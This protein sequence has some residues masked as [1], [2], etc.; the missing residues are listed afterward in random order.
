MV[1]LPYLVYV[2]N[3]GRLCACNNLIPVAAV[4]TSLIANETTKVT[5]LFNAIP[6]F[7][8][9]T[10]NKIAQVEQADVIDNPRT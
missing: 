3:T 1:N 10:K 2:T 6:K 4:L 8:I 5:N 7:I 9:M